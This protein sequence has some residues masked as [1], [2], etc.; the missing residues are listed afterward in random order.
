MTNETMNYKEYLN[1]ID[2]NMDT[3]CQEELRDLMLS[4]EKPE[5]TI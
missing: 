5:G 3:S 4:D 1:D 2:Y